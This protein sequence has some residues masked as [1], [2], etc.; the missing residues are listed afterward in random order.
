MTLHVFKIPDSVSFFSL[1]HES[2]LK[3]YPFLG[4]LINPND[5]GGMTHLFT[6]SVVHG[7]HIKVILHSV[8]PSE[9]FLAHSRWNCLFISSY[10]YPWIKLWKIYC[11]WSHPQTNSI[12]LIKDICYGKWCHTNMVNMRHERL[13]L[14]WIGN[15]PTRCIFMPWS[16]AVVQLQT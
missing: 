14:D 7:S 3:I 12:C 10:A 8:W 11:W 13:L 16:E 9:K 4:F 2:G 5:V 15:Q 1:S 6:Y